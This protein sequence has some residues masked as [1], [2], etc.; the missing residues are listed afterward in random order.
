VLGALRLA[1]SAAL[2]PVDGSMSL[3]LFSC[4]HS[5]FDLLITKLGYYSI[6]S[7][8]LPLENIDLSVKVGKLI[9]S[10]GSLILFAASLE[11]DLY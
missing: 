6:L 5:E 7:K 2:V 10:S 4:F 9:R 8:V 11:L 1:I 3:W